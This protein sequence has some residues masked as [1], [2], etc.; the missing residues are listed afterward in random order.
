MTT[1]NSLAARYF[2]IA[3]TA[4]LLVMAFLYLPAF[5]ASRAVLI[6]NWGLPPST[7]F[8]GTAA[9]IFAIYLLILLRFHQIATQPLTQLIKQLETNRLTNAFSTKAKVMEVDRFRY[10]LENRS[11]M[12]EKLEDRIGELEKDQLSLNEKL[13]ASSKEKKSNLISIEERTRRVEELRSERAVLEERVIRL[14]ANLDEERKANVHQ[15]IEKRSDEIYSQME[16][17]VEASALKSIWL[18]HIAKDLNGPAAIIHKTIADL[19]ENWDTA[20]FA[21]LKSD[22]AELQEQGE[23]LMNVL[24]RLTEKEPETSK[25]AAFSSDLAEFST[26]DSEETRSS[27]CIAE[28]Q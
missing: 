5:E 27:E 26:P 10:L 24:N 4:S 22:L 7:L 8:V 13:A 6:D 14:E 25:Q 15:E 3:L 2:A 16:K 11:L 12:V 21:R 19:Q 28:S 17:A 18:P 9:L 1:T 23:I 20:S